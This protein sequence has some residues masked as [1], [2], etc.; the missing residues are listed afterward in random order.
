MNERTLR[1]LEFHKVLERLGRYISFSAGRALLE[2]LRPSTDS[3]EVQVRLDTTAEARILLEKRPETTIGGARDI[4]DNVRIAAIGRALDPSAFLE[5]RATLESSRI[6]RHSIMK[7][8]QDGSIYYLSQI[9]ARLADLPLLEGEIEQTISPDGTVLDSASPALRRIREQIRITHGRLLDKLNSIISSNS[10]QPL[11]QESIITLRNGRYVIPVKAEF[12]G[13]LRG[14]IH[15]QSAS[16]QTVYM[17][18]LATLDL[19]NQWKQLQLDENAEVERVLRELAAKVGRHVSELLQMVE[20]LAELDLTF[21]KARYAADL[22][23]TQPKLATIPLPGTVLPEGTYLL[24]FIRARHPLISGKVVPINFYLGGDFRALVITGPNTGGKTVSLKTAAL[25]TLMA[26]AGLHLPVEEGS[27]TAVFQKIFADIGDEQSIEQSLSTFSSHMN[28]I[29]GML[30]EIDRNTLVILDE[31]GAGTDPAEGAA[32]ARSLI[33]HILQREA[34]AAITTHYS[35]LK[36][37]AYLTPGVQNASV[38]FDVET[39][40]PTY[41]LDIGLPGRSN[42]L[43]IALRL[44]LPSSIIEQAR[45]YV[46]SDDVQVD[47]LISKIQSE[48][49]EAGQAR[50]EAMKLKAE[51]EKQR[52]ELNRQLRHI[53]DEKR[54]AAA[55]ARE[56]ARL[57]F[58]QDLIAMREESRAVRQR[59]VDIDQA[60]R[61]A[62]EKTEIAA[63]L[64]KQRKA[65]AE[66]EKLALELQRRAQRRAREKA[67]AKTRAESEPEPYIGELKAG[68]RVQIISLQQEGVLL[69]GPDTEGIYE[70][71]FGSF[72]VKI[73]SLD[74]KRLP[75]KPRSSDKPLTLRERADLE[76]AAE[77]Q[78]GI[79]VNARSRAELSE[80]VSLELDMRGWRAEEVAAALDRYLNDAYL[81]N[82]PFV[83]LVHGKGTGTLRQVVRT[84]LKSHPLVKSFRS[85]EN[86]EGGEGVTV[87]TMAN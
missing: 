2:T 44:G 30:G 73:S 3:A 4:R 51:I 22:R 47:A 18:P 6:L 14:I 20:A 49:D 87:A 65:L 42:A 84:Y 39:L 60:V 48:R 28:N 12:K 17:E 38:R 45:S 40:S 61:A 85:G 34:H 72:K 27:Q 8:N 29:I 55:A 62:G 77:K 24:N 9:A 37:Y 53:E 71:Q 56:E 59:L 25:L 76:G 67:Q 81:S 69:A 26:M 31:L 13:Q 80:T 5:I 57:E 36:S 33:E 64:E 10:H 23:A 79:R 74:L 35:E 32:L 63:E 70:V 83:R 19:N 43:A 50:Y 82:M 16:G 11:L 68:D 1:V 58:E 41:I 54:K 46:S 52:D 78:S 21:A 7:S 15:D 75:G 86:G 66:A